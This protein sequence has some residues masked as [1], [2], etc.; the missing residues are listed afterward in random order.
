MENRK[1]RVGILFGGKSAEHEVSL[2]SAKNV[3]DAIDRNIYDVVLLGIEKS[4]RWRF[5]DQ[6]KYLLNENDPKR[7]SLNKENQKSVTLIPQSGGELTDVETGQDHSAVDVIFPIL[8]G[9][10]GEDGAVQGMLKLAGVPFVGAGILGSA[11]GMDKDVMKRLMR[12][13][14]IPICKFLVFRQNDQLDFDEIVNKLGLP[15]FVKPANLGS[16]VGVHK[17]TDRTSFSSA[18]Q[19]SFG[20]DN[21]ILIEEFVNGRELECAVLGNRNPYASVVGEIISISDFYSYETKYIDENG[22]NLEIPA[23]IDDETSD[24]VRE[25][26]LEVFRVLEGEGLGRVDFFMKD[27]GELIVNEINTLPGFANISMYPRLWEVSG[28]SYT[29][30]ISRLIELSIERFE[31]LENL[32]TSF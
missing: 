3:A 24:R 15:F 30:L 13:A 16:S 21:K 28:L 18:I 6:A 29:D 23:A 9:P 26:A 5:L 1:I 4:G 19:D 25:L 8:H 32:K 12:D 14:G 7:I 27:T 20:Y 17:V 10:F 11:I 31:K 2:Q 22:A